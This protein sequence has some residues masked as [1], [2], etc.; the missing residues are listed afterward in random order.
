[1]RACLSESP[2][3]PE[4]EVSLWTGKLDALSASE[5]TQLHQLLDKAE[6]YRAARFH[7]EK[8]RQHYIAARGLL[9]ELVADKLGTSP[10]SIQFAYGAHGKPAVAQRALDGRALHFNLSHSAGWAMFACAWEREVGIDLESTSRLAPDDAH[11]SALA[12]RI[13]SPSEFDLWRE[14]PDA[15]ARHAAFLRAWTRKEAYAK[16][17]GAG[18]FDG[19]REIEVIL[20]AMAPQSSLT[21]NRCTIHDL[22]APDGFAAA[23]ALAHM[24]A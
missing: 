14:L 4:P 3:S 1:M 8:D 23:L 12:A 5:L 21:F 7:F 16:A 11:L 20:D 9:R 10:A 22:V 6:R 2:P 13:L 15:A 24:P 17:T 18:V 19:L